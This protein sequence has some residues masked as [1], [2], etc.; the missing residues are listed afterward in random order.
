MKLR[1]K[2]RFRTKACFIKRISTQFSAVII[3]GKRKLLLLFAFKESSPLA[4]L[5]NMLTEISPLSEMR[6][7]KL[8]DIEQIILHLNAPT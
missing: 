5:K 1:G 7:I 6:K 8:L 3:F 2:K 4:F